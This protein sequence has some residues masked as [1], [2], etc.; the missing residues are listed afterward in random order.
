MNSNSQILI[1]QSPS[2]NVKIDVRLEEETVWLTQDHMAQIFG[3]AKSTI[4]EKIRKFQI[5]EIIQILSNSDPVGAGPRACPF[6]Q[7]CNT[8]RRRATT[9]GLPLRG[10]CLI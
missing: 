8:T 2:G 5:Y 10:H 1:R 4:N 3:R 6:P 7:G 9:G